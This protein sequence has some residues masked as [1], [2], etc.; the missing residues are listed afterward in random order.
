MSY[1]WNLDL[2][3]AASVAFTDECG[4][5]LSYADVNKEV[6]LFSALLPSN[7]SLVL[8][9]VRNDIASVI[10]YL[11]C[12]RNHHPLIMVDSDLNDG[13]L[14]KLYQ[15]YQP[16]LIIEGLK[17]H[18]THQRQLQLAPELAVMLSTSGSTGSPKLVRLSKENLQHNANS[19]VVYLGLTDNEVAITTMPLHYSFGLSILNSHLTAGA[20]IVLTSSSLISKEFWNLVQGESVTSLSGVPYI[21][22]MLKKMR[23]ERFNTS[24]VR[25][26]TQAGGRLDNETLSYFY[27]QCSIKNQKL[28]VMYGQTEATARISY[29]PCERLADKLGSI[30][31]PI[32]GGEL[33]IRDI[34]NGLVTEPHVEGELFYKR[35]NV[36]L[37]YAESLSDLSFGDHNAGVLKT[38]DLGYQDNDGFF[39]IT[40]R[41]KRFI[42]IYGLR[43]SLDAV[44]NILADN[45]FSA[46]A[47]GIDDK[48]FIFI[49]GHRQDDFL[50]HVAALISA[51]LKI[52]INSI[53]VHCIDLIPRMVNGK[54]N[55]KALSDLMGQY[56]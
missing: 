27:K 35:P 45:G 25:Y 28:Y 5:E 42:K 37:G 49:E 53:A 4:R 48:L 29:L 24:S 12:L 32:P 20:K 13:L 56:E 7:R 18:V 21:F 10:A 1:F 43:V 47:T 51:T 8:L 50:Q 3:D 46:A 39:Y 16:N 41:S 14:D 36:M 38:G 22:Q 11:A 9:K 54:V 17:I 33:T 2:T 34:D 26:L 55:G 19:I 6:E 23:Y 44:D 40:G 52:N 30:G 15:T 31:I